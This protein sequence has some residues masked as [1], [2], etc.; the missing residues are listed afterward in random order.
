MNSN[1]LTMSDIPWAAVAPVLVLLLAFVAYCV[2]DIARHDVRY[3]P[4]WAWILIC[5]LFSIPIGGIVYLIVGRDSGR[6]S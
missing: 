2:V 1:G 6:E 4:K 5:C 3:L